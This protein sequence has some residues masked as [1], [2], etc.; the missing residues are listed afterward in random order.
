MA[1]KW[2]EMGITWETEVVR[3][4][5][6]KTTLPGAEILTI[7]D[8]V[9]FDNALRSV[10]GSLVDVLNTSNSPRVAAQDVKRKHPDKRGEE[11]RELVWARV[12]GSRAARSTPTP[13]IGL[14]NGSSYTGTSK[15]EFLAAC[16]AA[17]VDI[18]LPAD[19]ARTMAEN[20][21]TA[22]MHLK[23]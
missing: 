1:R 13:T 20:M 21:A 8:H 15:V 12:S 5:H 9:K 23:A 19:V 10:G 17:G 22:Y 14:P 11:L 18:G 4:E 3:T 2:D 7:T 16:M 6:G